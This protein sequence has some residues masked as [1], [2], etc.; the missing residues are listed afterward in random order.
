MELS[1]DG[2]R[3][4]KALSKTMLHQRKGEGDIT[5]RM[6]RKHGIYISS[7]LDLV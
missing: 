3:Q 6:G 4:R 1:F 7:V 5:G 2:N